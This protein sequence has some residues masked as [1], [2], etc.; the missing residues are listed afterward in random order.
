MIK[1]SIITVTYNSS[2]TILCTL[3]SVR[4]QS[5]Q[6]IEHIIIDGAS[7]DGTLDIVKHN[8]QRVATII[9]EPDNGIYDAL[10]K[11]ISV[12][13]GD[14][15]G[16]L[17]AD[18]YFSS[19]DVVSKIANAFNDPSVQAV[20]G[21]L[22]YVTQNVEEKRFRHWRTGVFTS[23]RLKRGW[24]PPHPTL[25]VKSDI[26]KSIGGFDTKYR[27]SADYDFI[28]RLFSTPNLVTRYIPE[29]L[30]KMRTGGVSN[31][32]LRNVIRKSREDLEALRS[33]KVG[34]IGSLFMKN[35]RKLTQLL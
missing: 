11:G 33:S 4:K 2:Q 13:T 21:D 7:S 25:Y 30:V 26:Y 6:N 3:A 9:S 28:L 12:A 35:L 10:N 24:M 14:I 20:Y 15:I 29:V 27:I 5:H 23:S 1:I 31:R 34:G 22:D 17:H 18:D 16:F 19:N 8:C 32:S